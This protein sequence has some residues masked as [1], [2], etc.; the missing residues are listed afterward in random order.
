MYGSSKKLRVL[1]ASSSHRLART[2]VI[3]LTFDEETMKGLSGY[4]L[5]LLSVI[6]AHVSNAQD[7][8]GYWQGVEYPVSGL[9]NFYPTLLTITQQGDSFGGY[10]FQTQQRQEQYNALYAV[11]QGQIA[12]YQGSFI[13]NT[14]VRQTKADGGYWCTGRIDFTYDP[15]RQRLLG[16]A[17]FNEPGCSPTTIELYRAKTILAPL[18]CPD[19]P[20]PLTAYGFDVRWY[21]DAQRQQLLHR[22]SLYQPT[23]DTTTT[24]Y[25]T[26]SL[27]DTESPPV[28][29]VVKVTKLAITSSPSLEAPCPPGPVRF[30]VSATGRPPLYYQLDTQPAQESPVFSLDGPGSYS[31]TVRDSLG[32]QVSQPV[33][34]RSTCAGGLYLPTSFSPNG[35]GLNDEL[36]VWFESDELILTR[37]S[38]YDRWGSVLYSASGAGGLQSGQAIWSGLVDGVALPAGLY[39]CQLQVSR[40]NGEALTL[41]SSLTILP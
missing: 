2:L 12:N 20:Q 18:Y 38:V 24:L 11:E 7:I 9:V 15:D 28:P 25:I 41:R 23:L 39:S 33:R 19:Q 16:Q 1:A 36:R 13:I 4:W 30:T 5:I 26:Q 34:L 6:G 27:F 32:C 29:L 40:P 31:L 37:F 14:P 22:G 17:T 35:D 3:R 21:A 8:A 10:Y